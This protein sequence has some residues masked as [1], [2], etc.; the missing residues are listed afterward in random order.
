MGTMQTPWQVLILS[1]PIGSGKA[2]VGQKLCQA[3]PDTVYL[4]VYR[5]KTSPLSLDG[6]TARD[7]ALVTLREHVA[8]GKRVVLDDAIETPAELGAYFTALGELPTVAVTLMPSLEEME[9]RDALKPIEQ[10]AGSRVGEVYAQMAQRLGER[11]AVI[12][13]GDETVEDTVQHVLDVLK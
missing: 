3:L 7:Q 10:R 9:R 2:S 4:Q 11:G 5:S 12:N 8:A 13:T 1:G 6:D